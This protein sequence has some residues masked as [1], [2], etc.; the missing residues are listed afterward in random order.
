MRSS[1]RLYAFDISRALAGLK[2]RLAAL[3]ASNVH[4]QRIDGVTTRA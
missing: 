3:G 2:P 4:P 1:G